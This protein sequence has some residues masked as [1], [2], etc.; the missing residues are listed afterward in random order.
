MHYLIPFTLLSLCFIG[1]FIPATQSFMGWLLDEGH[2]V[3][4]LTFGFLM[5]GG[6]ISIR[7]AFA[8][9]CRGLP[10]IILIFLSVFGLL[11]LLVGAEEIAWGQN[12][13]NFETPESLKAINKQGETTIHNISG[14][15]G[16]TE[17]LRLFFGIGG[18]IGIVCIRSTPFSILAVPVVLIP[19]ILIITSHA[20]FDVLEDY[21]NI[22]NQLSFA[23][24]ETAEL[25][26]A[27]IAYTAF[28]YALLKQRA[29]AI[30]PRLESCT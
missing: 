12:Y 29:V 26:E 24:S 19:W 5:A 3:E 8:A 2:P 13:F 30:I 27:M 1:L 18:I 11:L 28:Q 9:H 25:V 15:H 23:M 10:G 14:F 17:W 22:P 6:I 21:T 7:T 4:L 20:A 16:R